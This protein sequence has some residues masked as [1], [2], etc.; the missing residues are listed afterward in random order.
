MPQ[1]TLVFQLSIDALNSIM[2]EREGLG[3]TGETY[4]VGPDGLMRSDSYLDPENHSVVNSFKYPSKGNVDTE[5]FKLA[6]SGQEGEKVITDYNGQPVL[7]AY[8]NIDVFGNNWALLAEIDEQEAFSAVT[9][10]RNV[11]LGILAVAIAFIVAVAIFFARSL[12]LPV[13]DLMA[14]MRRVEKEGDFLTSCTYL[15][16]R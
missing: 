7:S 9:L 1:A 12:T 15:I 14:T 4:L 5:A 11:L 6:M 10:L 2:T 16:K 3:E 8:R 13:H